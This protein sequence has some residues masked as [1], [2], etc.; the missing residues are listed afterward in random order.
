MRKIMETIGWSSSE[1]FLTITDLEGVCHNVI[2]E[3]P[4]I[5]KSLLKRDWH[6][7][8]GRQALASLVSRQ[9]E[10]TNHTST[11]NPFIS[12]DDGDRLDMYH[13]IRVLRAPISD[14]TETQI[15]TAENFLLDGI[16]T[17]D[18]LRQAGYLVESVS[19][20]LCSQGV[21]TIDHRIFDCQHEG[22]EDIRRRWL[23]GRSRA[24][25]SGRLSLGTSQ[26]EKTRERAARHLARQGLARNPSLHQPL[27][28]SEGSGFD[29]DTNMAFGDG[30]AFSDGGCTRPFHP[31]LARASWAA[32][33]TDRHGEMVGMAY[34]PVWRNLP[35]TSSTAEICAM[36]AAA[37][38][39]P[40]TT[41][42]LDMV[43]DNMMVV[44]EVN[45]P[46]DVKSLHR[47]FH[48]GLLRQ[49]QMQ[50]GWKAMVGHAHHIKSHILDDNPGAAATMT[51]EELHKAKG[52]QLVDQQA[53]EAV[54]GH[55]AL[56]ATLLAIDQ[57][58]FNTAKAVIK[59]AAQIIP[60]FPDMASE[61]KHDRI[62]SSP[63]PPPLLVSPPQTS[64]SQDD[65]DA[66]RQEGDEGRGVLRLPIVEEI[67]PAFD[68]SW[69]WVDHAVWRCTQC[70]SIASASPSQPAKGT[71]TGLVGA[72]SAPR[73]LGHKLY[74]FDPRPGTA[75]A[76]YV[77]CGLCG[78]SGSSRACQYLAKPCNGV[79]ASRSTKRAWERLESG[80]HPRSGRRGNRL[81][82]PGVLL[83]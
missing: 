12:L 29:G 28:A 43:I 45:N 18:R 50:N 26:D 66:M 17:R 79:W 24:W 37:Q 82:W 35:Q 53:G 41:N 44:G 30:V 74:K 6:T 51:P 80:K 38:L 76:T 64:G 34:G 63:P 4:R 75:Y 48:S 83:E 46:R 61:G 19:C 56:E 27:P 69:V 73:H 49:A 8:L 57:M 70:G 2:E 81:F 22:F 59:V 58:A 9:F 72:L 33:A 39:A 14:L 36:G 16:W 62:S 11:E 25:L 15:T 68:H 21:D 13:A 52:N 60:A 71:C 65:H 23:S 40:A 47:A 77:C 42:H 78:A 5:L 54:G 31:I 10:S 20:P 3:G 32:G 1:N 7:K 67:K 55:P